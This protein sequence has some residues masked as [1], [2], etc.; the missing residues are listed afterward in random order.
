MTPGA[1]SSADFN[2]HAPTEILVSTSGTPMKLFEMVL[3][4]KPTAA[5]N[6]MIDPQILKIISVI[7]RIAALVRN[8]FSNS[9]YVIERRSIK[10]RNIKYDT[11][12]MARNN[13][14]R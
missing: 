10:Y 8:Q 11:H 3:I 4:T 1:N 13:S 12:T 2:A 14:S 6:G 5:G 7:I 9:R